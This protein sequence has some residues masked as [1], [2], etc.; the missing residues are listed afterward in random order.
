MKT[1]RQLI[2]SILFF[3]DL[4]YNEL[5]ELSIMDLNQLKKYTKNLTTRMS[6]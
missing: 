5:I 3:S 2:E 1:R 6:I 4:S